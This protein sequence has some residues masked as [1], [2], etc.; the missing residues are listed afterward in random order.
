MTVHQQPVW[1]VIPH[2]YTINNLLSQNRTML[3]R[4]HDIYGCFYS[5]QSLPAM[6]RHGRETCWLHGR[7][8]LYFCLVLDS[9]IHSCAKKKDL[10]SSENLGKHRGKNVFYTE[11]CS[12]FAALTI[13]LQCHLMWFSLDHRRQK[14]KKPRCWKDV[15]YRWKTGTGLLTLEIC[16]DYHSQR[17]HVLCNTR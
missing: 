6:L 13:G 8:W 17:C 2:T 1:W 11:Y 4:M 16:F 3:P 14:K 9:N 7:R 15:C 5:T 12:R 10:P